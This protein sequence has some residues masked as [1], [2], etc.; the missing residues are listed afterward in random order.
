MGSPLEPTLAKIFVSELEN[1]ILSE[2][3]KKGEF[4]LMVS[5]ALE[6]SKKT[7]TTYWFDS[8]LFSILR[9]LNSVLFRR[10][11]CA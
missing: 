2:L 5:K 9:P 8:S 4:E 6:R 7:A 1:E 11:S 3:G 10:I